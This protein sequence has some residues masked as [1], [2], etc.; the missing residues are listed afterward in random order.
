MNDQQ[1]TF[2][3]L[4]NGLNGRAEKKRL[5]NQKQKTNNLNLPEINKTLDVLL[6]KLSMIGRTDV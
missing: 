5:K 6:T 1:N 3:K 4:L 2:T